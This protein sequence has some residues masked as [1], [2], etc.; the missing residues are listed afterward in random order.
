MASRC[1]TNR[2]PGDDSHGNCGGYLQ[3]VLKMERMWHHSRGRVIR[4]HS[5]EKMLS[6]TMPRVVGPA[7]S[8][9]GSL[10]LMSLSLP[11]GTANVRRLRLCCW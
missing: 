11:Q 4:Q 5:T 9:S 6:L 8:I 1:T 3:A 10:K 7:N 2:M